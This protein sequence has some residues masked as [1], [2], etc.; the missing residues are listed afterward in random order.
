[1]TFQVPAS[2]QNQV[3]GAVSII[4]KQLGRHLIAIYLYGS[5]LDGGLKPESDIDIFVVVDK[6]LSEL[7]DFTELTP[8]FSTN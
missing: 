1:M 6:S 3:N 5:A 4:R 2:I 7:F 8:V